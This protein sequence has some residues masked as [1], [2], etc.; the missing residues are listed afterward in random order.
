VR[1]VFNADWED[2]MSIKK[3]ETRTVAF[4]YF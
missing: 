4:L 2:T 3:I 1:S